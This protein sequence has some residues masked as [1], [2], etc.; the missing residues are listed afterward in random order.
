MCFFFS[1]FHL[2][3]DKNGFSILLTR[4]IEEYSMMPRDLIQMYTACTA[5]VGTCVQF[6]AQENKFKNRL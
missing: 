2:S 5:Y 6:L 4:N 1:S 3:Y